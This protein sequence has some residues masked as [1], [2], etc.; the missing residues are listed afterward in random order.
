MLVGAVAVSAL[1]IG[2]SQVVKSPAQAAADTSAPPPSVMTAAVEKRV[3]RNSV[4]VRGTVSASQ[5]VRVVPAGSAQRGAGGSVVTAIGVHTGGTVRPGKVLIEVSGRP[6]IALKGD[7]PV[8]RDLKPGDEGKDVTQL[9]R[10]LKETGNPVGGDREGFFGAG[11][12]TA[13]SKLYRSVGYDPLPA[14]PEGETT[15]AGA[16]DAVTEATRHLEDVK[17][18]REPSGATGEGKKTGASGEES[19]ARREKEVERA[20]EDLERAREELA[21]TEAANGPMLPASEV[22]YVKSFPARVGDVG[23]RVGD[24][25][26]GTAMT[27]SAGPLVVTGSLSRTQRGLV[28]AGQRVQILSELDGTTAEA[29]VRSVSDTVESVRS[30]GDQE[31]G[32]APARAAAPGYRLT[33]AP[34]KPLAASMTGQDVR[35]TVRTAATEDKVLV[36]P[37]S[38]I[39]AGADGA[40]TV[41]VDCADGCRRRVPVTTGASGDGYVEVRPKPGTR[42]AAGE[43]VVVGA[44]RAGGGR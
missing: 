36:V 28:R 25:V 4:V 37:V 12:K 19:S 39:S 9:Q 17:S 41:T 15:L 11:T 6:V 32:P 1:G 14:D 10:A 16:R 43:R 27:I 7:L 3:L 31:D 8:Y 5:S 13:L 44:V 22:V 20:R 33:V 2:A 38:A 29:K 23:A 30:S 42:L 18:A 40:T 34:D 24:Q 35:L 21:D 26:S